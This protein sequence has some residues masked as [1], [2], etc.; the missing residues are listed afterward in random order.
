VL[1]LF[2]FQSLNELFFSFRPGF[3]S[4]AA[5]KITTLF[6][7]KQTFLIFF[8][9][10]PYLPTYHR[11]VCEIL[12]NRGRIL[13]NNACQLAEPT[14]QPAP[15]VIQSFT[16]NSAFQKTFSLQSGCKEMTFF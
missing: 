13:T 10:F 2:F 12:F 8:L 5:A 9:S 4:K 1:D 6:S 14:S 3:S 7:P 11:F 16:M 15:K